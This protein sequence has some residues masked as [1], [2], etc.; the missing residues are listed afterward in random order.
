MTRLQKYLRDNKW[1]GEDWID[2]YNFSYFTDVHP[3]LTTRTTPSNN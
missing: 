1:N 2:L 3:T